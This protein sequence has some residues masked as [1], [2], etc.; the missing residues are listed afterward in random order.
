MGPGVFT[1]GRTAAIGDLLVILV[2]QWGR[3]FSRPEGWL[4]GRCTRWLAELQWGRAFSRPEGAISFGD[5]VGIIELQWGR[6]FSRPEGPQTQSRRRRERASMGPG[7]FTP[8]RP[9]IDKPEKITGAL[10][11]GRAFSRPEG[12]TQR[13]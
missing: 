9:L 11:W 5:H 1:P 6:A 10:Q 7:V 13:T 3:A 12:G 2:L 8:G 4:A